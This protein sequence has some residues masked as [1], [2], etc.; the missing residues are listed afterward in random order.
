VDTPLTEKAFYTSKLTQM[1]DGK[2]FN[3]LIIN[4]L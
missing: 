3:L 1:K 4:T 2:I